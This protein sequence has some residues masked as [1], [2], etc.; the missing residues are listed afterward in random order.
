VI[1][2][3]INTRVRIVGE[4]AHTIVFLHALGTDSDIWTDV[5]DC[6]PAGVRCVSYDLRGHGGTSVGSGSYSLSQLSSDLLAILNAVGATRATVC[7]VS[8]G[9]LIA[10][11]AA[12]DAPDRIDRLVL[13]DTSAR[14]GS[15][16]SWQARIDAVEQRGLPA[17][18]KEITARWFAPSFAVAA[19][20]RIEEL[21]QRLAAMSPEGY[22]AACAALRDGDLRGYS[23]A[24]RA[25][26]YVIC[27]SEDVA[28]PPAQGRELA[29]SIPG[30]LF[31]E[32]P[33]TGHLPCIE[34]PETLGRLIKSFLMEAKVA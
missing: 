29:S 17:M 34:A 14:I 15:A 22:V 7:G 1:V 3:S 10:Q 32:I 6:M 8:L 27:G 12:L 25:R 5:V 30:A 19:S 31:Y 28:T 24:I 4:G 13:C 11:H 33:G 2:N 20:A 21:R 23:R 9:G 26:T 16:Q 18:A